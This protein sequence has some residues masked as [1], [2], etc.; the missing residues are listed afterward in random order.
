MNIQIA[1]KR[2]SRRSGSK[3]RKRVSKR[4]SRVSKRRSKCNRKSGRKSCKGRKRCSWVK[5]KSSG[6]RRHKAYCKRMSGGSSDR[7]ICG[8]IKIP[9]V[10]IDVHPDIASEFKNEY[11]GYRGVKLTDWVLDFHNDLLTKHHIT[12][13]VLKL[14]RCGKF[15]CDFMLSQ[16]RCGI[17]VLRLMKR[18]DVFSDTRNLELKETATFPDAKG[19]IV[20]SEWDNAEQNWETDYDKITALRNLPENININIMDLFNR[21]LGYGKV[22]MW[23]EGVEAKPEVNVRYSLLE[24]VEGSDFSKYKLGE[25]ER[26][27]GYRAFWGLSIRLF[28]AVFILYDTLGDH[29]LKPENIV[30]A[31]ERKCKIINFERKCD[32]CAGGYFYEPSHKN[33][34]LFSI[35]CILYE[36]LFNIITLPKRSNFP[37][38][39]N[40]RMT[41][42]ESD[43]EDVSVHNFKLYEALLKNLGE[44][45]NYTY[46]FE[47]D[48]L[49]DRKR[50]SKAEMNVLGFINRIINSYDTAGLDDLNMS[51][52]DIG[53]GDDTTKSEKLDVDYLRNTL[54][55]GLD[56]LIVLK[57][58]Y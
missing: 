5:R 57:R 35:M 3:R 45:S 29:G 51:L 50:G 6:K 43:S 2:R 52:Y 19:Y 26:I 37:T 7:G 54:W 55:E 31:V 42:L 10:T 24:S 33:R 28:T 25:P 32:H 21:V 13:K 16:S 22:D 18:F 58:G 53:I 41:V 49:V 47:K 48:T 30:W 11:F 27:C 1:G 39:E 34:N 4:R 9:G 38:K 23:I 14:I 15:D 12:F 40:F 46:L 17:L 44:A 36:S 56:E 20:K 8:G